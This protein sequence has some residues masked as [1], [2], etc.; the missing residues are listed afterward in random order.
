MKCV[1]ERFEY[2]GNSWQVMES[3]FDT[4]QYSQLYV[5]SVREMC[6]MLRVVLYHIV[7]CNE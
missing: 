7:Y 6:E 2:I 5:E 3:G 1:N 4:L